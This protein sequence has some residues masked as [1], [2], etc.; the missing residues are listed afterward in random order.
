MSIYLCTV[1]SQFCGFILHA[2]TLIIGYHS[3]E[4][5]NFPQNTTSQQPVCPL[6]SI[7]GRRYLLNSAYVVTAYV[8]TLLMSLL[9]LM[10][11]TFF[12]TSAFC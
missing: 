1:C 10:I 4:V 6:L 9:S 11:P 8:V 2:G 5:L 7:M 12:N 3:K